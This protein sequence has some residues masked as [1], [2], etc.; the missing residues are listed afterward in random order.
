MGGSSPG[1]YPDARGPEATRD[2]VRAGQSAAG[3][4][5]GPGDEEGRTAE[6]LLIAIIARSKYRLDDNYDWGD[7]V[8]AAP[9]PQG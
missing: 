6:T 1:T 7:S 4:G 8:L 5:A 3:K 9:S 2:P